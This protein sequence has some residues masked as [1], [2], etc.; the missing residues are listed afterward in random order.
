M[1]S[2]FDYM[3]SNFKSFYRRTFIFHHMSKYKPYSSLGEVSTNLPFDQLPQWSDTPLPSFDWPETPRPARDT[4]MPTVI[5][6]LNKKCQA[7]PILKAE[8]AN[9]TV[10]PKHSLSVVSAGMGFW[11]KQLAH[12][13]EHNSEKAKIDPIY[14]QK[15]KF[16]IFNNLTI[17][18]TSSCNVKMNEVNFEFT[19]YSRCS[20]LKTCY[21]LKR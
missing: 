9:N 16:E 15:S 5:K 14:R 3:G 21:S 17:F 18:L 12:L 1:I 6:T 4:P 8:N 20:N 13:T 7:P 2:I 10:R 11:R 19:D